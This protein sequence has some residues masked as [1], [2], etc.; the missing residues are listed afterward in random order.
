[1]TR[2]YATFATDVIRP[3]AYRNIDIVVVCS[4]KRAVVQVV[5][6][7]L[8]LWGMEF[9]FDLS[10]RSAGPPA[11]KLG[12]ER[13]PEEKA[14]TSAKAPGL[15]LAGFM[16]YITGHPIAMHDPWRAVG[17]DETMAPTVA[18]QGKTG[19]KG[20]TG[21]RGHD[22]GTFELLV[23]KVDPPVTNLKQAGVLFAVTCN[24]GAGGNG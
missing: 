4:S 15:S 3:T 16:E 23:E 19:T 13:T 24:G 18:Q 7:V 5:V 21:E 10:G 11:T 9:E 6:Q 1:M 22:A 12:M 8:S 2:A 17:Y 20:A 14:A